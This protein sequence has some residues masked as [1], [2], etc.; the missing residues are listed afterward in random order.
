LTGSIVTLIGAI[1]YFVELKLGPLSVPR[2]LVPVVLSSVSALLVLLQGVSA[3][4]LIGISVWIE[5]G[6]SVAVI[7]LLAVSGRVHRFALLAVG[8]LL[9]AASLASVDH[10]SDWQ[11]FVE[12]D[13]QAPALNQFLAGSGRLYWEADPVLVWVKL[14]RPEYFS[15]AQGTGAMFFRATAME[16]GKRAN[17]IGKLETADLSRVPGS[18]CPEQPKTDPAI[19]FATRLT[20]VCRASPD[21]DTLVL[22][23]PIPGLPAKEWVAPAPQRVLV[24]GKVITVNRYYRYDC[25]GNA[26]R[27][28]GS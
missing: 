22:I 26:T 14:R 20:E 9:L 6:T 4:P 19:P 5:I 27:G 1:T 25:P 11:R 24:N 15:C 10:R 12:S 8:L 7:G 3:L 21:L 17:I 23:R 13:E 28:L 18:L 16:F 2:R